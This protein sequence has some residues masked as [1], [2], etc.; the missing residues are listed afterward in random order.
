MK[1]KN[2]ALRS[3]LVFFLLINFLTPIHILGQNKKVVASPQQG[4][5]PQ[6]PAAP[7]PAMAFGLSE[8]TPV[9]LKLNRNMSSGTAKVDEKVDFDVVEDVKIGDVVVIAQGAKAIATVTEAQAKRRMGRSGKLNMNID[10]VQ[11]ASG[12][13]VPLRAIKGGSG[14]SKT[15]A[16]TGAMVATGILFFPAAPLFLFMKGKN[17]NIPKGTEITAYIAADTPLDIAKFKAQ[18]NLPAQTL[19]AASESTTT[20]ASSTAELSS[21]IIKSS[22]EGADISIGGKFMGN[23]QS[24]LRL[25]P[26]DHTITI[27]KAGYKSWQRIITLSAGGSTTID[28]TL[29]KLP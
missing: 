29:E 26:G 2:N 24:T 6:E 19:T 16:M 28:A 20:E 8:D 12:E 22:P 9:R 1:S 25:A 10:S 18:A 3:A 17:I 11:L 5:P 27:E 23:T 14:G 4:Q 21:V 13:K 7:R 15:G